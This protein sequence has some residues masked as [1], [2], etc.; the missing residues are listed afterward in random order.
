MARLT[1]KATAKAARRDLRPLILTALATAFLLAV[2]ATQAFAQKGPGPAGQSA[3][4]I[5]DSID[6]CA[7]LSGDRAEAESE[8]AAQGWSIDY[9]DS[10]G[11]YVWEVDASKTYAD[12]TYAS[13]FALMETYPT[14][15]ITYCSFTADS[16][17]NV[18]DLAA[19]QQIYDVDGE[20][21]PYDGGADGT[22]EQIADGVAYYALANVSEGYFYLQLTTVAQGGLTAAPR[23][24][25]VGK[26]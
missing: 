17:P 13:I 7:L 8:L 12:G 22:W 10:N 14:G 26:Q 20:V 11:P 1:N 5:E 18:P 21:Q 4:L 2:I 23:S 19:V 25:P 6:L 15:Q 3:N 9:S 24:G 16:V